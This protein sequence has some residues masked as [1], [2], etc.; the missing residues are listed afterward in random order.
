MKHWGFI[1][2]CLLFGL[3]SAQAQGI[4]CPAVT[5]GPD[6]SIACNNSSCVLLRSSTVAGFSTT[7]YTAQQIP[8]S[9]YPYNQGTPI[10]LNIDDTWSSVL[11]IGFDFCFF[12]QTYNQCVI[13]SN[14][15]ITFDLSQAG[16]Y[17]Q[18]PI[19]DP[20]PSPLNPTNSIMGP[21][22]DT[23][24]SIAGTIRWSAY[25]TP[26]CRVFVVSFEN[27]A[28]FDCNNLISTQ[29]IVLYEGT[30]VIET[31]IQDKP[32]CASWNDG[33]AIHGIQDASGTN[34]VVVP[35]RNY[36]SQWNVTN[37][38]WAFIPAGAPNHSLTWY[39]VGNPTPIAITDTVTVCPTGNTAYVAE[40]IY[41]SCNG[42]TV[43]V[44]DTATI[45]YAGNTTLQVNISTTAP[46][47]PTANDGTATASWTGAAGP[48]TLLWSTGDTTPTITNLAPG[49]YTVSVTDT[50]ACPS[51]DNA[52][53]VPPPPISPTPTQVNV[54]CNGGADGSASAPAT[55]G[56]GNLTYNWSNGGTGSAISGLTAGSYSVTITDQ[57]GCTATH[58]FTITEPTPVSSSLATTHVTC[59][60]GADG[61]ISTSASG[62]TGPY[63]YLW[64]NGTQ[65]PNA[66]N[67]LAGIYTVTITDTRGCTFITSDTIL[68][69]PE[70]QLSLDGDLDICY[71]DFT[72]LSATVTGGQQPYSYQW[73]TRPANI[74]DTTTSVT[75]N[76]T[77]DLSY[78]FYI[79]DAFGCLRY[80]SLRVVVRPL[81]EVAFTG[82]PLQGCDTLKVDFDNLTQ[83]GQ[84]YIWDFG[85]GGTSTEENP[86]HTYPLGH[87][88]VTLTSTSE[89]GC[90][91]HHTEYLYVNVI[92]TPIPDFETEPD[93]RLDPDVLLS[94]MPIRFY[95]TS[96]GASSFDWDFGNGVSSTE[97]TSFEYS[98]PDSGHFVIKLT[99]FNE[100]GC[101][102]SIYRNI[103][104]I[105]DPGLWV[106]TAFTPGDDDLNDV[107]LIS[108]LMIQEFHVWVYDRW[109]KLLFESKDISQGWDGRFAG[110][111]LPEGVYTYKIIARDN[112]GNVIERPGTVTLLR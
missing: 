48:T 54:S 90:I 4:S 72:T 99:G 100:L 3:G 102:V 95:N 55:G 59:F 103:H 61:S 93:I 51:T 19:G 24:P 79:R 77:S 71:G 76:P 40:V 107:F 87:F 27:V 50:T 109:G 73:V 18:W 6:T 29:Q 81:P 35:G 69:A 91:A 70:I 56:T 110:E 34:A 82:A 78:Y 2:A 45:N 52:L 22:H 9:P 49:S 17:C 12:G 75:D 112:L 10:L 25:G 65:Y 43:V 28:M 47:C 108:G 88:N 32:T 33:A 8:Y 46:S 5:A 64:S 101:P 105:L 16:G 37:D 15:L 42:S 26:P 63:T 68:E 111:D 30:N 62:G 60:G 14:G 80:D 98:Y 23:D 7:T 20:I 94:E 67:L 13:G 58:T 57:N 83:G 66:I 92:P 1:F 85:H 104:V 41:T 36:P 86:S 74:N 106:P 31:Y 84:S 96:L 44:H 89:Y 97:G 38:A 39:E 11:P 53:I 21:W